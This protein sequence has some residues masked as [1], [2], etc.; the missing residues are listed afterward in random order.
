[1]ER[2]DNNFLEA[3]DRIGERQVAQELIVSAHS[4]TVWLN[5]SRQIPI[6]QA[7][8]ILKI[9]KEINEN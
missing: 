7:R 9:L 8:A 5:I 6:A 3:S 1:M 2:T 4:H